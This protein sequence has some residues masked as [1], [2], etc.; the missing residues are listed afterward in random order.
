[1]HFYM[2]IKKFIQETYFDQGSLKIS[3]YEKSRRLFIYEGCSAIGIFSLTSGAFLAGF[4]SYLGAS[5]EFSGIIGAIPVLAGIM[6][7][8]SSMVF[9]KLKQRKF[10]VS[11]G[12]LVF[13][14]LLALLLFIPLVL[15]ETSFGLISLAAIYG[16]AY[17][18]AA[19]ITP[20]ASNWMVDLTPD[21]MRGSY[22]ATKDAYSLA[23]VTILTVIAG[24]VLD[25]FRKSNNEY[26]GF[27]T[28][29]L[30]VFL[31]AVSN[32]YYLARIKEPSADRDTISIK[33]KE[34]ILKPLKNTGYRKVIVLF[35]LWNVSLQ[36]AG[37]FFA[38]YMVTG[39]RLHYTYIMVMGVIGSLVRVFAAKYWGKL[40]D[41]KSWFFATKASIGMLGLCH[42]MWLFANDATKGFLVPFGYFISG[43]AWAGISIA[44]FNIQF[45][46]APK[47]G[48]T[49]YLGA[50]AAIGGIAGFLST[51]VGSLIIK[52]LKDFTFNFVGY[53]IGNMQ[54]VFALSGVMLCI[55]ALYVHYFMT[56]KVSREQAEAV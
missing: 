1:M 14:M 55:T 32:A 54:I 11:L 23:F 44:I 29:G 4:A 45:V 2:N 40:A 35:I 12:C 56:T 9:E 47:E 38:V 3:D 53:S 33:L 30:I 18:I 26:G 50:S 49:M 10:L 17:M 27:L 48:R 24:I 41:Q 22:F 6:Q 37:P 31:L 34:A 25:G 43:I 15:K 42:L 46:I 28:I 51:L 16:I 5:D 8:F 21:D 52:L 19:F 39:L 20:P 36:I 13:R 7:I